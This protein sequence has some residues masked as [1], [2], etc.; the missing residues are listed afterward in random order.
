MD[1]PWE[2][3]DWYDL[4]DTT[5]TAGPEREPEHYRELMLALPP[6][7]QQDHLIDVGAG[8]GKMAAIIASSYPQL[9]RITLIE[10]NA[11]KLERAI[12]RLS[13]IA[14]GAKVEAMAVRLGASELPLND[15]ATIVTVGSVFMPGLE[16][17]GGT[18]E[19]GIAWLRRSL[20]E[21]FALLQPGAW[22][23]AAETMAPPWAR[24][25]ATDPVRRL[26]F[27]ELVDE[28]QGAGLKA[29]ECMYR[30]R[31]RVVIRAKRP[32]S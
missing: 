20:Q 15:V 29:T 32:V 12:T 11:I 13:K 26:H 10:P 24:G 19:E 7:D 27:P 30:F 5:W 9:G 4:H 18:L 22:L 6:L 2:H 23:Y 8:T 21:I 3:P 31:D 17:G 14:P 16:L 28:L 25:G 1:E